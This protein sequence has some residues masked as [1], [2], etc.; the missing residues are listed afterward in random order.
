M[1]YFLNIIGRVGV[2]NALITSDPDFFVDVR[3]G[4]NP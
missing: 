1:Y 2:S 4:G 3:N